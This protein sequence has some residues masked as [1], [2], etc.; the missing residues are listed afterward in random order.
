[1][2]ADLCLARHIKFHYPGHQSRPTEGW[3]RLY[4]P[5]AQMTYSTH[6]DQL[7]QAEIPCLGFTGTS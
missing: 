6:L 7:A 1:M 2:Q 3:L 5:A 4:L